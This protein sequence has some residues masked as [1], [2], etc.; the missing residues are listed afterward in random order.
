MILDH[1]LTKSRLVCVGKN[2][3]KDFI[4]DISCLKY[5]MP[6]KFTCPTILGTMTYWRL[7]QVLNYIL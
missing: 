7:F 3:P 2:F 5:S 4:Q 1:T 6:K